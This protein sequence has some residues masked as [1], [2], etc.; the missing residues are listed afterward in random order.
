MNL[1]IQH[2]DDMTMANGQADSSVAVG[3]VNLTTSAL[4]RVASSHRLRGFR[5]RKSAPALVGRYGQW[6]RETLRYRLAQVLRADSV[7][8]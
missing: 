3:Q 7:K 8:L 5:R 4:Q 6:L 1:R 2:F